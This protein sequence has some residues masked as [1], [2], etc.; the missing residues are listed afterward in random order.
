MIKRIAQ[1]AMVL[2]L[3]YYALDLGF[4][5]IG[6]IVGFHN[7]IWDIYDFPMQTVSPPTWTLWVGIIVSALAI[8]SLG[9]AYLSVWVVLEA[10]AAQDFRQL[11]KRLQKMA[12]GLIGF[13]FFYNVLSGGVQYLIIIDLKN[14]TDFDMGW[15]PLDLDIILLITGIAI[16]AISQ[17]LERAW[18]AEDETKH[19]L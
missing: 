11:G 7:E 9:M 19:F 8:S 15:D 12:A 16:L 4:I 2:S 14:T 5:W 10:G 17:T 18:V 6:Q 3:S 13:W 1:I